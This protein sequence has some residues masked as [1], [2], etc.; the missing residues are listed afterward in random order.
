[1][2]GARRY[3][4]V[5]ARFTGNRHSWYAEQQRFNRQDS[6]TTSVLYSW[7]GLGKVRFRKYYIQTSTQAGTQVTGSDSTN[8]KMSTSRNT[9][10]FLVHTVRDCVGMSWINICRADEG[11]WKQVGRYG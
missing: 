9:M 5:K 3:F 7:L 2:P 4:K 10:C 1:M 8:S 6:R 11:E